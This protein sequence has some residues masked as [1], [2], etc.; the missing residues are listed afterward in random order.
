MRKVRLLRRHRP[1]GVLRLRILIKLVPAGVAVE[2][3][4]GV[5]LLRDRAQ[6]CGRLMREERLVEARPALQPERWRTGLL[7]AVL[8]GS[9]LD[10][11]SG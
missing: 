10:C 7:K 11:A 4:R 8:E 3:A 1:L 6:L 9:R 5:E 2:Q